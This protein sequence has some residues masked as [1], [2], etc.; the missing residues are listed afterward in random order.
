M[1]WITKCQSVHH[2]S[3][4]APSK[5][6]KHLAPPRF[7]W[8][9]DSSPTFNY[10]YYKNP[11]FSQEIFPPLS[12]SL[13]LSLYIYI[14]IYRYTSVIWWQQ[15]IIHCNNMWRRFTLSFRQDVFYYLSFFNNDDKMVLS[16]RCFKNESRFPTLTRPP[17]A[18]TSSASLLPKG[19][20]VSERS[21]LTKL[22]EQMAIVATPRCLVDMARQV[23]WR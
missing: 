18:A 7:F 23:S 19:C 6:L 16:D 15:Y 12:L 2:R 5:N 4:F 8:C 11:I 21:K 10:N 13:S 3:R 17:S 14:Y 20:Q 22:S 1:K 9:A